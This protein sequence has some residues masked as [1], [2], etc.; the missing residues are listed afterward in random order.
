A[1]TRLLSPSCR[2]RTAH[3][4]IPTIGSTTTAASMKSA[5]LTAPSLGGRFYR[6]PRTAAGPPSCDTQPCVTE[7]GFGFGRPLTR[8]RRHHCVGFGAVCDVA[9]RN[10]CRSP[11]QEVRLGPIELEPP[12][13]HKNGK[14]G[15]GNPR[16]PLKL[17]S[18]IATP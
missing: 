2:R 11:P 7:Q 16:S 17:I 12:P 15:S 14:G 4:T 1:E 8:R 13:V 6:K 10:D 9:Y 3:C 18:S 5:A